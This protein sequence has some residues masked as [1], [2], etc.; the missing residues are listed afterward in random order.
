M[1]PTLRG[2]SR[3]A[4]STWKKR[5]RRRSV[6]RWPVQ[7]WSG[8]RAS[9]GPLLGLRGPRRIGVQNR[10]DG[11][12]RGGR[13]PRAAA[14]A[15]GRARGDVGRCPRPASARHLR[16][17]EAVDLG[18]HGCGCGHGDARLARTRAAARRRHL[19]HAAA[20][21]RRL[22]CVPGNRAGAALAARWRPSW[23]LLRSSRPCSRA[24]YFQPAA[25]PTS[26][27]ARTL[28]IHVL[29]T[30]AVIGAVAIGEWSE[31]ATV[32]FLFAVAQY[33]ESRSMDR[34]RH[35]DPRAH[36]PDAA[37]RAR[38]TRRARTPRV[39]GRRRGWRCRADSTRVE[40]MPLD[41]TVVAG[42]SDVNQAPI[43]GES[44]PVDKHAGRRGVRRHDQRPRRARG[45]RHAPA[46]RHHARAHHPPRRARAGAA[47]ARAGVRRP[48]RARLHAGRDCAGGR[49]SRWCRRSSSA[50]AA[51]RLGLPRARAARDRVPVRAGHLD[52]GLDR[53]GAGRRGP[54]RRADQGRRPPRAR[55]RTHSCH[56]VR[57]DGHAHARRARGGRRDV[58]LE[59]P[60][61]SRDVLALAAALEA[62]IASIPIAAAI[63]ARMRGARRGDARPV[64][65]F[66]AL[67]GLGAEAVRRRPAGPRRQ[68]AALRRSEGC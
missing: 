40:K 30:V 58:P 29:M 10:R 4:S 6:M 52:A 11:L 45:A 25:R 60:A 68:P 42:S 7:G 43:T 59:R 44:L 32:I 36:G 48:V 63:V 19:L 57:Q 1:T 38:R 17:R 5:C 35:A 9:A 54:A 24:G 15:P 51:G 26:I 64:E 31:A 50:P 14:E 65:R 55:W 39:G 37:G 27:R 33:L 22:G 23:Q 67:P 16:R 8:E 53:V 21:A 46:A 56:R 3:R 41:G 49:S 66:H 2:C 18:H 47:R 20:S 34:A 61:P 62:Q 13:H 12:P 28:D